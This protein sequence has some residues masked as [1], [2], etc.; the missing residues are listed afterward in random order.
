V[1]ALILQVITPCALKGARPRATRYR[2]RALRARD[3][4]FDLFA[5]VAKKFIKMSD[6]EC[7]PPTEKR[8]KLENSSKFN[9]TLT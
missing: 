5:L 1:R 7:I 4:E 8:L 9:F 2:E 3:R 6:R